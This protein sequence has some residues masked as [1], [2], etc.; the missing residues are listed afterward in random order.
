[1]LVVPVMMGSPVANAPNAMVGM[2]WVPLTEV[3]QVLS[4]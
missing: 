1:M 4:W 3:V 2:I